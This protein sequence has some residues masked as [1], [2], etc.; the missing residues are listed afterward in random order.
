[1]LPNRIREL[2]KRL[3]LTQ[4][5]V[6]DRMGD[7][8]RQPTVQRLETGQM[9]LTQYYLDKLAT[10]LDVAPFE[11]FPHGEY[12]EWIPVTGRAEMH[13]NKS[14]EFFGRENIYRVPFA[15][16]ERAKDSRSALEIAEQSGSYLI[17]QTFGFPIAENAEYLI[18]D[19]QGNFAL[20]KLVSGSD[21]NKYFVCD[22]TDP[23]ILPLE[24]AEV[25][26]LGH[27]I[28]EYVR[29]PGA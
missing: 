17:Y 19:P 22:P 25:S 6:A 10:A 29:K 16:D 9:T 1:M 8:I 24:V 14:V 7:K 27:I 11:L 4:Q 26:I 21:G 13:R 5:Q 20:R 12:I 2:R 18:E 23:A 15:K 3:G 28:A